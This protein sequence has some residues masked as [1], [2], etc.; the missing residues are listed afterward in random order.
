MKDI[1]DMFTGFLSKTGFTWDTLLRLFY[2]LC[3]CC[4]V[5]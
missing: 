2:S 4:S 1:A 3:G 5:A